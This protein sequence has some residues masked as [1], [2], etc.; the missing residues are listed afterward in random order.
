MLDKELWINYPAL[1]QKYVGKNAINEDA[2]VIVCYKNGIPVGCGCF[3]K[4]E[5]EE[6]A[7]EVKRMFVDPTR[8]GKGI[9]R[10]ILRELSKWAKE[11]GKASMIL[12]TGIKQTEAIEMYKKYG[13]E[14]IENYGDYKGNGNSLCMRKKI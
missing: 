5:H 6:N 10:T 12:E 11:Q 7:V 4:T 13:F 14:I 8:R 2:S 1:Q 9:G 3:R